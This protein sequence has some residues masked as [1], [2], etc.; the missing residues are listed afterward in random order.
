MWLAASGRHE[1]AKSPKYRGNKGS[2]RSP[3]RRAMG[4]FKAATGI[5]IPL[6]APQILVSPS[7][8]T[9]GLTCASAAAHPRR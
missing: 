8:Q 3:M 4:T 7:V 5:R 6:G 9:G 2:E 1:V